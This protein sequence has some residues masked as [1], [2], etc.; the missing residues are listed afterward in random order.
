[1]EQVAELVAV[2]NAV[3][4][5]VRLNPIS[6]KPG[7]NKYRLA[8][9]LGESRYVHVQAFGNVNHRAGGAVRL[10]DPQEGLDSV[11]PL[12]AGRNIMLICGCKD[13]ATCHRS[14]VARL[15][16]ETTGAPVVP[17]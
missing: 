17:L 16:A 8:R 15:I 2:H 6:R 5:D 12:L 1:L 11:L 10:K 7:F 3:L 4:V 14:D 9:T 13:A